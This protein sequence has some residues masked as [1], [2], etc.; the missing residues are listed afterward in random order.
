MLHGSQAVHGRSRLKL[1][2]FAKVIGARITLHAG[3]PSNS[4]DRITLPISGL[5]GAELILRT[6]LEMLQHIPNPQTQ[7]RQLFI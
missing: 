4:A 2:A 3:R 1:R 6:T 7:G 5:R